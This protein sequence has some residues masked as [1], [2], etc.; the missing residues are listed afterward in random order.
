MKFNAWSKE[1]IRQGRKKLTSRKK[2]YWE[3]KDVESVLPVTLPW[4]FIREYLWRDE[5][6]DSPEE[7]QKVINQI[8]RRRVEDD[9]A[10]CV[11]IL[12][13]EIIDES[14]NITE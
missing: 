7:L 8:F 13:K 10:F 2:A 9:E 5:G 12:K 1:R 4:W 6:A 11:H 3:D 14:I